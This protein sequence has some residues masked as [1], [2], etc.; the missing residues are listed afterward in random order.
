MKWDPNPNSHQ[1]NE[2]F[3]YNPQSFCFHLFS[4]VRFGRDISEESGSPCSCPCS[5]LFIDLLNL[6][7]RT[8]QTLNCVIYV[9]WCFRK[10]YKLRS[11]SLCIFT[12]ICS[13]TIYSS[14]LY[15]D[16]DEEASDIVRFARI[17]YRELRSGWKTEKEG[18]TNK[19]GKA[20]STKRWKQIPCPGIR[21]ISNTWRW[22]EDSLS[23]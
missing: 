20:K 3:L 13:C 9:N 22:P 2:T 6:C 21:V 12:A 5:W 17:V 8:E 10:L 14:A 7:N 16:R 15:S 4:I 11:I 23:R 19:Q 1:S 18:K